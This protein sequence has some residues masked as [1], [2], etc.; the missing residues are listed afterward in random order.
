MI[1]NRLVRGI[2][3]LDRDGYSRQFNDWDLGENSAFSLAAAAV[4]FAFEF[5]VHADSATSGYEST[6]GHV[7][8][9]KLQDYAKG[10]VLD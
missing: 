6:R 9:M 8:A 2:L 3:W 4:V 10:A 1:H 5:S 7:K